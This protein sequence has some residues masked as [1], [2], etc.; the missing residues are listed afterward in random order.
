[1]H[2]YCRERKISS[3]RSCAI[4]LHRSSGGELLRAPLEHAAVTA[5]PDLVD[6]LLK[7]WANGRA[8]WQGHDGRTLLHAGAEGGNAHVMS[9]E[10]ETRRAKSQA[11][12]T[13]R[14]PLHLAVVGGKEAAAKVLMLARA[15]MNER[16]RFPERLT[17][18]TPRH[19]RRPRSSRVRPAAQRSESQP[20]FS[21]ELLP[22][23]PRDP[24]A[25]VRGGARSGPQG[26]GREA[27]LDGGADVRSPRPD[28]LSLL[29]VA[30]GWNNPGPIIELLLRA[31][32][33]I[34]IRNAIGQTPLA[35]S[36]SMGGC[37]RGHAR[38]SSI[39]SRRQT[40]RATKDGTPL[41]D[42]CSQAFPGAVDMLLRWGADETLAHNQGKTPGD[43]VPAANLVPE[44][45]H[46]RLEQVSRLLA[47]AP[48]NRSWRR[49]GWIA[50]CR[51]R[52]DRLR[53]TA[54]GIDGEDVDAQ[55]GRGR[56]SGRRWR[57]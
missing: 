1:M 46:P 27:L 50:M 8:G 33:S 56:L 11:Q 10:T 32:L 3:S 34:E 37:V 28:S 40:L 20:D 53:R 42:A 52:S 31:G 5:N 9:E 57:E 16:R 38:L 45:V 47:R 19:R 36:A 54:V 51:A 14:T 43:V 2:E 26:G 44:H 23:P 39:G 6:K 24:P 30:G 18:A 48:Q 13:G 21:A 12:I 35:V 41:H 29:H 49:R 15:D 55:R 25:S 7:A 17:A 22:H 4:R